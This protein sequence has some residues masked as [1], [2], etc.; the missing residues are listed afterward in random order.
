MRA[1]RTLAG[2]GVAAALA[3]CSFAPPY[4]PPV[5]TTAPAYREIGP[6]TPAAPA[7][8]QPRGA[9]W[10]MFGDP[11]LDDLEMRAERANPN[12]ASAVAAYDQARAIAAQAR[13]G[14]FPQLDLGASRSRTSPAGRGQNYSDLELSGAFA[15]E[16][17][18]WGRVRNQA[19]AA[20]ARAEAGGADLQSVRLSLQAELADQYLSLRGLEAQQRLLEETVVAYARALDLTERQRSGGVASGLDVGRAQT[21]LS[22]ARAQVTETAARRA[23]TEHA[24]AVLVGEG[25]STF[26]VP[27]SERTLVQP[28]IPVAAPS[29]LLQRR[30]DIVAAERRV[31][32]ANAEIG[33]ARAAWFPSLSIGGSSGWRSGGGVDLIAAPNRFWTLGP[34]LIL[35]LID[36]GGRRAGVNLARARFEE[37]GADYRGTVLNAFREVE[38][39][40]TL[41]NR[42]ADQARDQRAAA[43]AASRTEA[44]ALIRYR[45][46]ASGFLDV[47]TAETAALDT[48]RDFIALEA[49][50]LQASVDLVRALGGGWEPPPR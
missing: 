50:R 34:D 18:L 11:V 13:S 47:V 44:L 12:L 22:S 29:V 27:T 24:I 9:W 42:L 41:A 23:L 36:G 6:W 32:A 10:T 33:V 21:Q 37:A 28:I 43:E 17:D 31:A 38:D 30:P 46:G 1:A 35:P 20:G 2:A 15:Y 4:A 8:D 45:A 49:R 19:A 26:S 16:I 48:R 39:Q 7:A 14:L 25:A 5:V 40:L 3:G